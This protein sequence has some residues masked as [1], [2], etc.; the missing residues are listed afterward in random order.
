MRDGP[1]FRSGPSFARV[2]YMLTVHVIVIQGVVSMK[3][4]KRDM[5]IIITV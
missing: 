4:I 5:K 2:R 3:T 1:I